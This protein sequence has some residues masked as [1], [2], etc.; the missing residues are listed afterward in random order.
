LV[1]ELLG[2]TEDLPAH[3]VGEPMSDHGEETEAAARAVERI[4]ELAGVS[5]LGAVARDR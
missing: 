1:E 2:R 3:P 5:P 4:G